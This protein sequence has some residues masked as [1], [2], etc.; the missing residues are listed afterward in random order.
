[1]SEYVEAEWT[2][3]SLPP[4]FGGLGE[5]QQIDAE[6]GIYALADPDDTTGGQ[7]LIWHWCTERAPAQWRLGAT[8]KHTLVSREPLHLEPSLRWPC[9]GRHGFIRAGRW[10]PA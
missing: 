5:V 2:D 6:V 9:C 1:M 3:K 8:S 4:A 7:H 10:I